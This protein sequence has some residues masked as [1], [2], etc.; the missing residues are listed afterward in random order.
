MFIPYASYSYNILS[1]LE[2]CLLSLLTPI[3]VIF[4]AHMINGSI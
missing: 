3:R 1:V 2:A 4:I